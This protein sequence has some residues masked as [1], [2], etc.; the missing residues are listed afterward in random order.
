MTLHLLT[1][2]TN[3][4]GTIFI[5]HKRQIVGTKDST[6]NLEGGMTQPSMPLLRRRF[7]GTETQLAGR[8]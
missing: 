8:R 3:M 2:I 5:G 6:D 1:D 4:R 7:Y